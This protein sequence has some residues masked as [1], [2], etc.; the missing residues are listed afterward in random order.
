[1]IVF[2]DNAAFDKDTLASDGIR[3]IELDHIGCYA[4]LQRLNSLIDRQVAHLKGIVCDISVFEILHRV[5]FIL[6]LV[7]LLTERKDHVKGEGRD[8]NNRT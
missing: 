6:P 5:S 7:V 4:A 2:T 1:M 3:R 8:H